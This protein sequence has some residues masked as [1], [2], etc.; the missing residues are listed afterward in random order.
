MKDRL[1]SNYQIEV[2]MLVADLERPSDVSNLAAR[3][4]ADDVIFVV[5]NAGAGGLRVGRESRYSR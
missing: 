1:S 5:N 2:G 3:D 4:A